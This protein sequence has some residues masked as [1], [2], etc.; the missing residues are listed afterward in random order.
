M[1]NKER[2]GR[3]GINE[4]IGMEEWTTYLKALLGGVE[5]RVQNK[6]NDDQSGSRQ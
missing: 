6:K 2:G 3:K 5:K 4:E 1:I